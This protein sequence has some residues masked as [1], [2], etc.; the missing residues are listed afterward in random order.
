[1]T[2]R[3][4]KYA[5]RDGYHVRAVEQ[6]CSLSLVICLIASGRKVLQ[7]RVW[8]ISVTAQ[9]EISQHYPEWRRREKAIAAMLRLFNEAGDGEELAD[10]YLAASAAF[11]K[12]G[13]QVPH[14]LVAVESEE[15]H[16]RT[17]LLP[18]GDYL[19]IVENDYTE[20]LSPEEMQAMIDE[21]TD[22]AIDPMT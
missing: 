3:E 19:R 4:F 1:M 9:E 17:F 7:K 11:E 18:T 8:R 10:C 6:D 15:T 14:Q 5:H 12:F 22:D 21:A 2:A 13:A 20:V 16:A